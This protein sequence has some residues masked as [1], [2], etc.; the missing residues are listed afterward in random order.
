MRIITSLL[1]LAVPLLA[2]SVAAF[3]DEAKQQKIFMYINENSSLPFPYMLNYDELDKDELPENTNYIPNYMSKDYYANG[4]SIFFKG[5][6]NDES[7]SFLTELVLESDDYE[8]F[9][10]K[11]G[12]MASKAK[13]LDLPDWQQTVSEF[14]NVILFNYERT[15]IYFEITEDVVSRIKITTPSE[16]LGNRIY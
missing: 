10:V 15:S 2:F 14:P 16:D 1:L 7:D 4:Y 11:V 6:P 13:E 8:V 3:N 5:Y 9:S 12:D